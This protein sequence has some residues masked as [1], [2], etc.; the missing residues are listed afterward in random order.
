L[1]EKEKESSAS[2]IPLV[3]EAS[4]VKQWA[5]KTRV[6]SNCQAKILATSSIC[7]HC[8]H[9]EESKAGVFF[10]LLIVLLLLILAGSLGVVR[11]LEEPASNNVQG[12]P[13]VHQEKILAGQDGTFAGSF[14]RTS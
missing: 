6:C 3:D 1:A 5:A 13:P 2:P 14:S 9:Q 12:R 11:L 8:G 7:S 10:G 4:A